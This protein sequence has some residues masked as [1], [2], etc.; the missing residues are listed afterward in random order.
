[1]KL[2]I[3]RSIFESNDKT[4]L[5]NKAFFSK[6]GLCAVNVMGSPGAGK[7][8]VIVSLL[9][10]LPKKLYKAVIEGDVASSID[11]DHIISQGWPAVQINTGGGCHLNSKMIE[12]SLKG[13]KLKK[14]GF[15]FIENIGNLICPTEFD[16]GETLRLVVSSVSEGDDK[17]VKYP[18]MFAKA[19]I[20]VINKTDLLKHSNFNKKKFMAGVKSV[21]KAAAV[22]E[23]SNK[24]G[25]GFKKL[26]D[27]LVQSKPK[28]LSLWER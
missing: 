9:R 7:T 12:R 15:V 11:T 22:F 21:N 20:V 3:K 17:P 28:V 18:S 14:N 6:H 16:L 24:K 4:A 13:L 5:K 1:M 8:S 25:L 10:S 27:Y 23:V 26:A 19:D 2:K